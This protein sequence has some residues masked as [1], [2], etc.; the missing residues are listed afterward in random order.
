MGSGGF[1]RYFDRR[2][3]EARAGLL[4]AGCVCTLAGACLPAPSSGHVPPARRPHRRPPCRPAALTAAPPPPASQARDEGKTKPHI[5]LRNLTTQPGQVFSLKQARRD[6]DA[7][8]AMVRE[9][10]GC[11]GGALAARRC[12]W[13]RRGPAAHAVLVRGAADERPS[14]GRRAH[15]PLCRPSLSLAPPAGPV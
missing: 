11:G 9:R 10:A 12:C 1:L 15:R 8:Y 13:G 3:D 6:I 7:V 5:I 14:A 4:V 2:T